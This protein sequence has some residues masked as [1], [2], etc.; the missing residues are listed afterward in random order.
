MGLSEG[1]RKRGAQL[2]RQKRGSNR[3][4]NQL[5]KPTFSQLELLS[6]HHHSRFHPYSKS[7]IRLM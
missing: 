6:T 7:T 5:Q 1:S 2:G 4:R 3:Q